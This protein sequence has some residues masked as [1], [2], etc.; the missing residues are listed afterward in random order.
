[1]IA[2]HEFSSE[3]LLDLVRLRR[4]LKAIPV[5]LVPKLDVCQL[6]ERLL[7]LRQEIA[8]IPRYSGRHASGPLCDGEM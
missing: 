7:Q 5:L 6:A 4:G 8:G 2:S 1:M 3:A